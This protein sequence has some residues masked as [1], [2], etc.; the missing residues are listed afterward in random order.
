MWIILSRFVNAGIRHFDLS[1]ERLCRQH[2]MDL[3]TNAHIPP[4]PIYTLADCD[5]YI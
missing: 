2:V 5:S 1:P 3:E 4:V